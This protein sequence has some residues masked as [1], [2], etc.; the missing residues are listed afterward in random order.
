MYIVLA[1]QAVSAAALKTYGFETY[2]NGDVFYYPI[3]TGGAMYELYLK[4]VNLGPTHQRAVEA[5]DLAGVDTAY[6]VVNDYW[7]LADKIIEN[8]KREADDWVV[9]DNGATT[10][11]EFQR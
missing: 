5:M 11:F 2:F 4:M 9:I 10:V 8:A 7:F 3:P 6:F 1:N